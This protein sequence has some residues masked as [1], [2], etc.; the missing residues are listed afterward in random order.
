MPPTQ[1]QIHPS[2]SRVEP[3]LLQLAG[4]NKETQPTDAV[5]DSQTHATNLTLLEAKNYTR[6]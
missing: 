5:R 4:I 2:F 6:L 1:S 3:H